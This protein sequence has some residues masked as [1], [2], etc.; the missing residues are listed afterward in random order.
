MC[1]NFV[2]I[3]LA[4]TDLSEDADATE[5]LRNAANLEQR[6]LLVETQTANLNNITVPMTA[7]ISNVLQVREAQ[8]NMHVLHIITCLLYTSPSPR[9][10]G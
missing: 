6:M 2:E 4:M 9:D 7:A 1:T 3:F 10:R 8:K 5:A